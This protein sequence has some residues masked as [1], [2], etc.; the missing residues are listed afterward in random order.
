MFFWHRKKE[1]LYPIGKEIPLK[2]SDDYR[3]MDS[4]TVH[5]LKTGRTR[6]M[7]LAT[8][9]TLA[10]CLIGLRLFE[11][12]V[13]KQN[14]RPAY[15]STLDLTYPVKRADILDRNG[16]IL[17]T[18]LPIVNL[19]VD[20]RYMPH[21]EKMADALISVFPDMD[22][23][24]LMKKLLSKHSFEYLRRNLTPEEQ[25]EVNRLGYPQLNFDASERRVYPQSNLFSHLVGFTDLDNEGIAGLELQYNDRLTQSSS[26]LVLS[27]DVRIQDTVHSILSEAVEKFHADGAVS[28][29]VDA[30]NAE[31]LAMVSLP[32]FDLNQTPV[33]QTLNKASVGMYELGSV[34]KPFTVAIG[35]ETGV[36]TPTSTVEAFS[37][38]KLAR[39]RTITDFQAEN[40]VLNIPEVL[41]YSSNIGTAKIALQFGP[42]VQ[43]EFLGRFHFLEALKL[44]LPEA[45][46]PIVQKKWD[47]VETATISYGYGLSVSPLHLVSA[48]RALID[49]GYY[50]L[51]TFI[52]NANE[53][54]ILEQVLDKK[55]STRMRH[56][57]RGV[58]EVGSGKRAN[59][60]G[61]N[62]IGKTGTAQM[63]DER[64]RY[65]EGK[66]RTSFIGAFPID[67]PKYIV[68]VMIENPAK[69]KED[70]YFNT[71]GWNACPTGGQIIEAIA[72]ILGVEPKEDVEKPAY[73]ESAYN[74][75]REKKKKR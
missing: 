3:F 12:T 17:A 1:E 16:H 28:L 26:P 42:A 24:D 35:L 6:M 23:A 34:M 2:E 46:R 41:I 67:N 60:K 69:R 20:A 22:R 72:P 40:R 8:I 11:Q 51:P 15:K 33:E 7:F 44:D 68:Y 39:G 29:V 48:F 53:D 38:Y 45:G 55:T 30:K 52:K 71:A 36:V 13:L 32:D 5:A 70:W 49:G 37:P 10:F 25:Y 58:V 62:V 31:I 9:F 59:I 65:I 43:K 61:Y 18:S 75:I 4:I 57:L 47:E 56:M 54:A 27:V 64:G 19:Y 66:V 74:Y 14:I 73:M 21:P 50:L 63:Q